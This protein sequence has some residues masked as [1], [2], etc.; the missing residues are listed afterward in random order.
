MIEPSLVDYLFVQ[1]STHILRTA[2]LLRIGWD[3]LLEHA[4]DRE[5]SSGLGPILEHVQDTLH[6]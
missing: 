4:R 2:L 6:V 5:G 1:K 3:G